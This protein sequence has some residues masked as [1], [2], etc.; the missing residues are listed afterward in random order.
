MR[1]WHYGQKGLLWISCVSRLQLF[2]MRHFSH[3]VDCESLTL[4]DVRYIRVNCRLLT[5]YMYMCIYRWIADCSFYIYT[6]HLYRVDCRSFI[7]YIYLWYTS[8]WMDYRSFT[9]RLYDISLSSRL[10]VIHP[11]YIYIWLGYTSFWIDCRL[12]IYIYMM[13]HLLGILWVVCHI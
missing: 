5:L 10:Q 12:F 11:K 2:Y 7:I 1:H 8:Y 6:I 3:W 13:H 9:P 4:F